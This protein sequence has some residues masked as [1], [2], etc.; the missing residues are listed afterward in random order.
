MPLGKRGKFELTS[1][2]P[3]AYQR[4]NIGLRLEPGKTPSGCKAQRAVLNRRQM[5]GDQPRN[6]FHFDRKQEASGRLCLV[7]AVLLAMAF[8]GAAPGGAGRV[9]DV[10]VKLV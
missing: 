4:I 8:I 9:V 6:P 2:G 5:V 3:N 10:L 1:D 7:A